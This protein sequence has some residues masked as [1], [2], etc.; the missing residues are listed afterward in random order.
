MIDIR[1]CC[2]DGETSK[3]VKR[4][5]NVIYSFDGEVSCVCPRTGTEHGWSAVA[6]SAIAS[7]IA[8]P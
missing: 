1:N 8:P 4:Q 7:A 2:K 6:S 5:W 3:V